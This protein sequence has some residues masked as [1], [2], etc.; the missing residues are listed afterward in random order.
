MGVNVAAHTRHI[1]LGSAPGL[2]LSPLSLSLSLSLLSLSHLHHRPS[3]LSYTFLLRMYMYIYS[4]YYTLNTQAT[5]TPTHTP[6]HTQAHPHTSTPFRPI[7]IPLSFLQPTHI[8]LHFPPQTHLPK[9]TKQ[10]AHFKH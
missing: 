9:T 7:L 2:S 8:T 6:T 3:F 4:V 10:H 1:F 5:N